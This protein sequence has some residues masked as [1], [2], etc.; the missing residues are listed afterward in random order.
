MLTEELTIGIYS[1]T[2]S[3]VDAYRLRHHY[4]IEQAHEALKRWLGQRGN[5][6]SELLAM[7]KHFPRTEPTVRT[8]LET[9]L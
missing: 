1:P 9:L 4:G 8:T 5:Q 7:A 3:I 2:R 6:P